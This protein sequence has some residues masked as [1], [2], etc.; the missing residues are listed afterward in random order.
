MG[1]GDQATHTSA[2]LHK[3]LWFK[4]LATDGAD[5]K[6][7]KV[8]DYVGGGDQAAYTSAQLHQELWFKQWY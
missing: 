8:A 5:E 7:E 2:Q 1:S 6:L 4:Y 3:E